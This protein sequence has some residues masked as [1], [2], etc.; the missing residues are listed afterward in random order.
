MFRSL[1]KS[2][3]TDFKQVVLLTV[4]PLILLSLLRFLS[5]LLNQD[6]FKGGQ[7]MKNILV[8]SICFVENLWALG[9]NL[10]ATFLV[11]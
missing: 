4:V 5:I 10:F 3:V 6:D 11:T 7:P 1:Y 8:V 9:I 2:G